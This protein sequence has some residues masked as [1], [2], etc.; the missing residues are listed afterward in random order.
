VSNGSAGGPAKGALI[1]TI[2]LNTSGRNSVHQAATNDPKS[3]PT[4]AC[5]ERRPSA[6]TSPTASRTRFTIR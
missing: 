3:C 5:T 2:D 6:A 1:S 4:T